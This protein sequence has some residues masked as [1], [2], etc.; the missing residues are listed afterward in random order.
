[1]IAI[2]HRRSGAVLLQVEAE[3]LAGLELTDLSLAGADAKCDDN[4]VCLEPDR[5][6]RIRVTPA[7]R[8]KIEAFRQMLRVASI[9][10]TYQEAPAA[11]LS[12]T[13]A[14]ATAG[15]TTAAR[16][17]ASRRLPNK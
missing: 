14:A 7:T 15:S 10:D 5:P 3:Y 17:L 13:P 16:V 6:M 2:K 4:F 1:M 12:A 9:R 8:L 11:A